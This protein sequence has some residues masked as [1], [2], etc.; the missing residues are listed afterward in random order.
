M[1]SMNYLQVSL[2]LSRIAVDAPCITAYLFPDWSSFATTN[3]ITI[4][5]KEAVQLKSTS[6]NNFHNKIYK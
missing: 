4:Q 6:S 3:E 5:E 1:Y 2:P